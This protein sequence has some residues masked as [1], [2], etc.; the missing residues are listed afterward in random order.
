MTVPPTN[1]QDIS[2]QY[3]M[4]RAQNYGQSRNGADNPSFKYEDDP[5][6]ESHF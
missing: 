3:G 2:G 5:T 6:N 4:K 1:V